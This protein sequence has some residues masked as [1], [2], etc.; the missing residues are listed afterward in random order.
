MI[1][2]DTNVWSELTRNAGNPRV[3]DWL[4][5]HNDVLWLSAI[6]IAEIRAGLESPQ[7]GTKRAGLEIWLH[8]LEN[9]YR[10]RT[11][12][13]DP[14]A[15][16]ALGILLVTKPQQNKMLDTLLAAQAIAHDCQLATRNVKD[17]AWTGVK[18]L[19]P[20]EA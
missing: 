14:A 19:N 5:R 13:F 9:E 18:M 12:P 1:I 6:V 8:T 15:A 20:W 3:L 17:F 4:E 2:P 11:L 10:E 16:H 7:A